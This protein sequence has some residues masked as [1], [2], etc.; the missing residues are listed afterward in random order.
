L[1]KYNPNLD[2]KTP[3]TRFPLKLSATVRRAM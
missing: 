3:P 2:M 1:T